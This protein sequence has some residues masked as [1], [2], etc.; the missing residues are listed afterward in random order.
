[1]PYFPSCK[2]FQSPET[3]WSGIS[4]TDFS[5]SG[6]TPRTKAPCTRSP[7][8]KK[9]LPL[10][11]RGGGRPLPVRPNNPPPRSPNHQ[12]RRPSRQLPCETRQPEYA[13]ATRFE[14]G[15]NGQNHNQRGNTKRYPQGRQQRN[16]GNKAVPLTD[17]SIAQT[18]KKFITH[19]E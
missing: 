19:K 7:T 11:I 9:P 16:K 10:D 6:K 17:K 3:S 8:D 14:N 5:A 12:S 4:L 15:H 18:D 1:M 2:A 13:H